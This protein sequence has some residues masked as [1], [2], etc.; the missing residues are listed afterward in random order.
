MS[1]LLGIN[2]V[3]ANAAAD[4]N[5]ALIDAAENRHLAIVKKLLQ[6]PGVRVAAHA[7]SNEV[8]KGAADR[9]CHEIVYRLQKPSGQTVV[10]K[11]FQRR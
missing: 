6:F 2:D 3:R 1:R 5:E 10:C 7:L 11:E 4:D 9:G 8:I